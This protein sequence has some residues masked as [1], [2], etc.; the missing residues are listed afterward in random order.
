MVRK[1]CVFQAMCVQEGVKI[2]CVP[3]L[4]NKLATLRIIYLESFQINVPGMYYFLIQVTLQQ[5][6][7]RHLPRNNSRL[8][9]SEFFP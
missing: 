2:Q 6:I 8:K 3:Y 9:I 5:G 7:C 4:K 1:L